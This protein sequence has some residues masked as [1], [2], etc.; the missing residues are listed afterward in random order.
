VPFADYIAGNV[1][2]RQMVTKL[3]KIYDAPLMPSEVKIL[4]DEK[5]G[6]LYGCLVNVLFFPIKLFLGKI[7]LLIRFRAFINMAG[8]SYHAARLIDYAIRA[9]RLEPAGPYTAQQVRMAVDHVCN[10]ADIDSVRAAFRQ[11]FSRKTG[12]LK[13]AAILFWRALL[14]VRGRRDESQ[15]E[16]AV[17]E[18]K[19]QAADSVGGIMAPLRTALEAIPPEHFKQLEEAMDSELHRLN[20][21]NLG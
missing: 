1:V 15:V 5:M 4:A 20:V 9:Q 16:R 21:L 10:T 19:G 3:A 6:C 7:L 12:I 8:R 18:A 11:V 17:D 13:D 2:R 14:S